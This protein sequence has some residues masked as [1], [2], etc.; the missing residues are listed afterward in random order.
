MLTMTLLQLNKLQARG[1]GDSGGLGPGLLI[2]WLGVQMVVWPLGMTLNSMLIKN[3]YCYQSQS[4][5]F[6]HWASNLA[7]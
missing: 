6:G 3:L 2:R 5:R 7:S 4:R 1:S